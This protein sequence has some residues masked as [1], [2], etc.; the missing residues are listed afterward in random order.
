MVRMTVATALALALA[1]PLQGQETEAEAREAALTLLR[2]AVPPMSPRWDELRRSPVL[3]GALL[4]IARDSTVDGIVRDNAIN[5]LGRVSGAVGVAALYD[6]FV[7]ASP[8]STDRVPVI[9][10]LAYTADDADRASA[11][12]ILEEA[13]ESPSRRDR[14]LAAWALGE[15]G[16]SAALALLRARLADGEPYEPTRRRIQQILSSCPDE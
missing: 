6:L 10:S 12:S 8:G 16:G 1:A 15:F 13:L 5:Q 3:A 14:H 11:L 4:S 7:E 9:A 2:E